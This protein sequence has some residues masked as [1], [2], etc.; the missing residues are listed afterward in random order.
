MAIALV[1]SVKYSAGG[2]GGGTTGTVNTTGATLIVAIVG[3]E[4][5]GTNFTLPNL[6]SDNKSNLYL[7][8]T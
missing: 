2:S 4:N 8:A 5:A 7:L 1:T 3:F 6:I